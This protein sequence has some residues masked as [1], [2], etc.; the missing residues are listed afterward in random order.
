METNKKSENFIVDSIRI[1]R[2]KKEKKRICIDFV[3]ETK[4]KKVSSSSLID[5]TLFA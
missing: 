2:K 5:G 1:K 4:N 3:N